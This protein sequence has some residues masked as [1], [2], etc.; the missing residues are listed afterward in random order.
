MVKS[1]SLLALALSVTMSL[2]A[3]DD[4]LN[5]AIGPPNAARYR[6]VHDARDWRNPIITVLDD[7][8]EVTANRAR[9]PTHVPIED[10][11]QFLIS[12]PVRA[13]PYGRVVAQSDQSL[14]PVPFD[15][16]LRRMAENRKRLA[17]VLKDLDIHVEF[18]P[19]A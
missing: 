9:N 1:V 8:I 17:V 12:L 13:W 18:W 2:M 7:G 6:A 4:R 10:V 5:A 19:S 15:D 3:A 14:L 11:K 16:Y